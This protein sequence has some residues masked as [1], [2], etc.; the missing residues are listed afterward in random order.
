MDGFKNWL[1]TNSKSF[2][3]PQNNFYSEL[4]LFTSDTASILYRNDGTFGF[5]QNKVRVASIDAVTTMEFR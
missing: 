4:K 2:P 3:V 1:T 5:D